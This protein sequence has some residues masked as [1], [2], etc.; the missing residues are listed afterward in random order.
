MN[1]SILF[2]LSLLLLFDCQQNRSN[3]DR[4]DGSIKIRV[5]CDEFDDEFH[6]PTPLSEKKDLLQ[7]LAELSLRE[8]PSIRFI[9]TNQ[10][11]EIMEING[12][13]N[14]WKEGWS[15]YLNGQ[16]ISISGLKKG[17][18]VEERDIIEIRIEAIERV[19]GKPT[20]HD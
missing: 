16:F 17:V 5:L 3:A 11:V 15:I 1:Y 8:S 6:Y 20:K 10:T 9:S 7:V 12:R 13:Q 19:F 18:R 2:S 14:T 4:H